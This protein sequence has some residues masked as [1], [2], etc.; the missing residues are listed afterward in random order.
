MAKG[1]WRITDQDIKECRDAGMDIQAIA[2]KYKVASSTVLRRIRK[3]DGVKKE[4]PAVT[5]KKY[6]KRCMENLPN[7]FD[8]EI[9]DIIS[10]VEKE[11]GPARNKYRVTEI[12]KDTYIG[13]KLSGGKW[14]TVFRKADYKRGHDPCL[15]RLVSKGGI[16]I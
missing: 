11:I 16:E 12:Y 15:V 3:I 14:R 4:K 6:E 1:K 8:I 2:A 7:D 13:E 10:A 9:G 5:Q